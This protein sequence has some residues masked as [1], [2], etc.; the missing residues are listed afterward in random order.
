MEKII[1]L[2]DAIQALI[3]TEEI[4]GH[5][6]MQME[7]RLNEIPAAEADVEGLSEKERQAY[8][9]GYINGRNAEWKELP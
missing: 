3:E 5:A 6:Y 2:K 9:L 4:K 7:R 1:Y 8:M